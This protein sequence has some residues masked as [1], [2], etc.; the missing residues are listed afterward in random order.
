M[1]RLTHE[2]NQGEDRCK[3]EARLVMYWSGMVKYIEDE[4][5]KCSVT[6]ELASRTDH[7]APRVMT[8][9]MEDKQKLPVDIMTYHGRDNF[10]V[11]GYHPRYTAEV[12]RFHSYQARR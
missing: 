11:L 7:A 6:K 10:A 2:G 12:S 1:L 4:V 8:S 5:S 3:T 9:Q